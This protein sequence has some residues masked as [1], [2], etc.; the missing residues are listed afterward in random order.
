[1]KYEVDE[2]RLA[3]LLAAELELEALNAGGVDN[4]E[5]CGDSIHDALQGLRAQ[6]QL[7]RNASFNDIAKHMIEIGHGLD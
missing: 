4:W 2:T 7:D 1:M 5:W 3:E 6:Y